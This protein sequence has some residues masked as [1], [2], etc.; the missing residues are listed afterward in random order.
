MSQIIHLLFI[1]LVLKVNDT[2]TDPKI[3]SILS[4]IKQ[5]NLLHRVI[6]LQLTLEFFISENILRINVFAV[7]YL[8]QL[9]LRMCVK[10]KCFSMS[11]RKLSQVAS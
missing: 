1:Y 9:L 5:L 4:L 10:Y 2:A 6:T 8:I 11:I 3:Y 7:F